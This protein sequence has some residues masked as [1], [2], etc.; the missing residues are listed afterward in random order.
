MGSR[1]PR[2]I[3]VNI[4]LAIDIKVFPKLTTALNLNLNLNGPERNE[5]SLIR[6]QTCYRHLLIFGSKR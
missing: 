6:R 3:L 4:L 5:E 1:S 2:S